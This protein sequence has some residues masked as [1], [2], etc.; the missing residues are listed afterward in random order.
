MEYIFSSDVIKGKKYKKILHYLCT[1]A[2]KIYFTF[3]EDLMINEEILELGKECTIIDVPKKIR[4]QFDA[5]VIGY[6]INIFIILYIFE[7]E[8]LYDLLSDRVDGAV[9]FYNGSMEIIYI[10]LNDFG[11]IYIQTNDQELIKEF[12]DIENNYSEN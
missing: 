8:S 11:D 10:R 6:E 5:N 1:I 2:D 7:N 12:S 3:Y 4:Q 9:L